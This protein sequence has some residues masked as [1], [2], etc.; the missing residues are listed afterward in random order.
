MT[1][2]ERAPSVR[3]SDQRPTPPLVWARCVTCKYRGYARGMDHLLDVVS[4]HGQW[5]AVQRARAASEAE[6]A[7]AL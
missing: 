1:P 7:E 4:D 3:T 2:I 5:C 6:T